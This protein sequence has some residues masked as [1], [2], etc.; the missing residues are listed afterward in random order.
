MGLDSFLYAKK[1]IS[2]YAF[3]GE[4]EVKQYGALVDL[5]G[6]A[7]IASKT[8]PGMTVAVTAAYWRKA[9]AIHAWFVENTAGGKDECQPSYVS[10]EQLIE[11]VDLTKQ[12]IEKYHAGDKDGAAA[13]LTPT[14]GFFF[15]STEV[16]EWYLADLESTVEQLEPLIALSEPKEGDLF[17]IDFE[18]QASW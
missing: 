6:M 4:N 9:N 2:G 7:N 11:L 15:G 10:R 1:Y 16:D 17:G 14:S 18:Y 12:A 13:L 5:A 3:N 8:S